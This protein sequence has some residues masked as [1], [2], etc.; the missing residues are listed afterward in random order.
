MWIRWQNKDVEFMRLLAQKCGNIQPLVVFVWIVCGL[1]SLL[2]L[3]FNPV[4][5][6]E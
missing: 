4:S 2:F 5:C 3:S 1:R 6:F